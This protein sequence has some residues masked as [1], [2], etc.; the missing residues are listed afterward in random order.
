MAQSGKSAGA[1]ILTSRGPALGVSGSNGGKRHDDATAERLPQCRRKTV[2]ILVSFQQRRCTNGNSAMA[3]PS[4]TSSTC[5][6]PS[7]VC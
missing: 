6:G 3:L 5:G 4:A 7:R 2:K 1:G